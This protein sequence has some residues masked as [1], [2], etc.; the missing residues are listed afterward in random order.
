MTP[1]KDQHID[2]NRRNE[3]L[4]GHPALFNDRLWHS[5]HE[6]C[7]R[8]QPHLF[9]PTYILENQTLQTVFKHLSPLYSES[10]EKSLENDREELFCDIRYISRLR[11]TLNHIKTLHQTHKSFWYLLIRRRF[12]V[13]WIYGLQAS[14]KEKKNTKHTHVYTVYIYISLYIYIFIYI[15]IIIYIYIFIYIYH[16]I[17][18]YLY[19]YYIY[20]IISIIYLYINMM[21]QHIYIY[22]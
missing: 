6:S 21:L 2:S 12:I 1:T 19:I 20:I 17:Y 3:L 16:Y 15:Y 11:R 7:K 18:I 8:Y 13:F 14:G 5:R 10:G 22:I 4:P 9:G